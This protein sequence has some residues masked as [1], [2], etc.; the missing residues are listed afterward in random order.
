V[1]RLRSVVEAVVT[2]YLLQWLPVV[3]V[4]LLQW[5]PVVAVYLLQWLPVVAVYLLH[6]RHETRKTPQTC[7]DT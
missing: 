4:Y 5:L 7:H 3:A 1:H 2:V 6:G